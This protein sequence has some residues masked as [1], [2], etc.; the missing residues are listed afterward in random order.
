M[1]RVTLAA[2]A[3][4]AGVSVAAVSVVLNGAHGTIGVGAA[5]RTRIYEAAAHLGY[6]PN[7]AA[8]SLRNRRTGV[9]SL[10]VTNFG[11]YYTEIARAAA[12]A[13]AGRGFMLHVMSTDTDAAQLAALAHLRT[14]AADGV[15]VSAGRHDTENPVVAALRDF[16]RSGI[17]AVLLH[18]RSPDPAIPTLRVADEAGA[19]LAT[20]HLLGLGHRR[21]AHY[22]GGW[23][24]AADAPDALSAV[25]DRYRGYRRALHAAGVAFNPA[26]LRRGDLSMTGSREAVGAWLREGNGDRPTAL[27]CYNDQSAFGAVRAAH[28]AGVRV[29]EELAV[30]GFDN[31]EV[32]AFVT[33]S[34][35]TVAF[36][37]EEM[38]RRATETLLALLDG[39]PPAE[40]EQTLATEVV[41]RESCG[42]SRHAARQ[43]GGQGHGTSMA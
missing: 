14:G 19:S 17:P 20:A 11:P 18:D 32:G 28:E 35:T 42:A 7:H 41:V 43:D 3:Q 13:A 39:Q 30:I 25:S 33:P 5:A 4:R 16:A 12:D 1:R 23:L 22:T 24:P 9:L 26:W 8:R 29:P 10:L 36:S 34:L 21:I 38:G 27:F 15:I 2:V 6:S 37:R 31:L 40:M